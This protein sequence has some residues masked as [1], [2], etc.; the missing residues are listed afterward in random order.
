MAEPSPNHHPDCEGAG[1]QQKLAEWTRYAAV[2]LCVFQGWMWL[3]YL[4]AQNLV[5]PQFEVLDA[6]EA[7]AEG[8]DALPQSLEVIRREW[9][10][11]H[12]EGPSESELANATHMH[13]TKL[14]PVRSAKRAFWLLL[15]PIQ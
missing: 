12:D 14:K 1:G 9:Q 10:R 5:Q 13:S 11:M 3:S 4:R 7:E 2:G 15:A 8:G 6:V